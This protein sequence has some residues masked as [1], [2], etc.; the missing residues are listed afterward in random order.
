MRN[1]VNIPIEQSG[2]LSLHANMGEHCR[3][4]AELDKKVRVTVRPLLLAGSRPEDPKLL[5]LV[6]LRDCVDLIPFRAYDVK[7]AHRPY[8]S[9]N[10]GSFGE[11]IAPEIDLVVNRAV[12]QCENLAFSHFPSSP[13]PRRKPCST[14]SVTRR[15]RRAPSSSTSSSSPAPQHSAPKALSINNFYTFPAVALR[16]DTQK[17]AALPSRLRD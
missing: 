12:K 15:R 6:L 10:R 17:L 3:V 2:K 14:G 4:L 13:K 5:G 8:C 9:K 16:A 7:H 11:E 1:E